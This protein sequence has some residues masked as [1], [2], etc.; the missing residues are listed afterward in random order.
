METHPKSTIHTTFRYFVRKAT[1]QQQDPLLPISVSP[2]TASPT[3]P[4]KLRRV[5]YSF[6]CDSVRLIVSFLIA[7]ILLDSIV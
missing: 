4:S 7:F 6:L 2:E 1:M 5:L 3:F